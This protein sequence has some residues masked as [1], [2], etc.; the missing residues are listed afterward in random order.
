VE[1][2]G[3][4]VSDMNTPGNESHLV[5]SAL[6][7]AL[8]RTLAEKKCVPS[9]AIVFP[10]RG[11]AIATN[12]KRLTMSWTVFDPNVIGVKAGDQF[13][14]RFLFH[15]FQRFD[16]RTITEPGPT[17]QLNKKNLEPL[18]VPIPGPTEQQEIADI[19]DAIDRKIDLHKRK[20]DVLQELFRSLL[21]KLMT[22]EIR[23]NDLS[24][25]E[26]TQ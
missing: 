22:G 26:I 13:D 24:I 4:K 10:K 6:K 14:T 21:H 5:T 19:L 23:V 16:L 18:L 1:V 12:K 11:A 9:N 3:I 2:F 7:K 20:R 17:P 15:W 25:P 8:S